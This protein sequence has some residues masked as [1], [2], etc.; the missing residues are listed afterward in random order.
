MLDYSMIKTDRPI[1][2]NYGCNHNAMSN[3]SKWRPFCPRCQRANYGGAV[4]KEGVTPYKSGRCCNQDNHLGFVCPIDYERPGAEWAF[5]RTEIDHID[6]N[7]CNN[8][9]DNVQELCKLCHTEKGRRNGDFKRRHSHK[10]KSSHIFKA[11]DN[12]KYERL[13]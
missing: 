9:L 1:C 10:K 12:I 11:G 13:Q 4:L 2:L 3:G 7:D 8:A 6:G 5:G